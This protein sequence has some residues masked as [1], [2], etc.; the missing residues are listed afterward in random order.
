MT[1]YRTTK[2]YES[3][4]GTPRTPEPAPPKE[5]GMSPDDWELVSASAVNLGHGVAF[6]FFWRSRPVVRVVP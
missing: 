1:E 3:I 6:Y 5:M 4:A 2:G